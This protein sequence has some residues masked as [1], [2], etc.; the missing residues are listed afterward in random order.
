MLLEFDVPVKNHRFSLRCTPETNCRQEIMDFH[1]S[2]DPVS[3]MSESRDGFG[4]V[5]SF[6]LTDRVHSRFAVHME[7]IARTGLEAEEEYDEDHI[8]GRFRYNW[9]KYTIA[10]E[11]L[12]KAF[13]M[14]PPE[15]RKNGDNYIR[16][17][18]IMSW[19]YEN[20]SYK[21][22]STGIFTTAEEAIAQGCGVCQ[23]YSH[24]MIS[25]CRMAGIP[26]RYAVGL[27]IG[28]GETH[29]W[30]EIFSG[31]RWYGLDPTN[32]TPVGDDHIR[33]SRGRNYAD[34]LI[35][36]GLFVSAEPWCTVMQKQTVKARVEEI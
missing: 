2:V 29:A 18:R 25:L 14:L 10:G 23:D 8:I 22:G 26:A 7:G 31:G 19:L 1:V 17:R 34:C 30:V 9:S 5:V 28:E 4:N 21:K 13:D 12:K 16:A 36:D 35:T 11:A 3:F 6:G 27:L 32:N 24:I 20:F 33:I 15:C